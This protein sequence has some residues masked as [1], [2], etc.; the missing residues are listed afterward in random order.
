[1]QKMN[2]FITAILLM[3]LSTAAQAGEMNTEAHQRLIDADKALNQVYQ[4]IVSQHKDNTD[5]IQQLRNTQR[6]WIKYRDSE[7]RMKFL[8]IGD[9]TTV[10][11]DYPAC[12]LNYLAQLTTRRTDELNQLLKNEKIAECS[13][14]VSKEDYLDNGAINTARILQLQNPH[15]TITGTYEDEFNRVQLVELTDNRIFF[16]FDLS[17]GR[18]LGNLE[19]FVNKDNMVYQSNQY[20]LCKFK[21]SHQKNKVNIK[22]LDKGWQCGYGNGVYSD[23]G[24]DLKSKQVKLLDVLN[25]ADID[26]NNIY[27]EIIAKYKNNPIFINRLRLSQRLWIKLRD[28]KVKIYFPKGES[29]CKSTYLAKL[30]QQ[31]MQKLREWYG[32]SNNA[33]S[34][35]VGM[36]SWKK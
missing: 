14:P 30:T 27:K 16:D 34:G 28:A 15:S 7:V 29:L 9:K 23:A 5:F 17:N 32:N 2:R 8:T 18:N 1:M 36:Y 33:C 20:G 10:D 26:L 3:V 22:T 24:L 11:T 19:G 21:I 6:L 25:E 12:V 4:Q 35:S 13:T 31:R